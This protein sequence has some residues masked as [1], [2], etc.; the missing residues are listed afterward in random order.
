[1][2]GTVTARGF[3]PGAVVERLIGLEPTTADLGKVVLYQLSYS[4]VRGPDPTEAPG[5]VKGRSPG[6]GPAPVRRRSPDRRRA[7]EGHEPRR[8]CEAGLHL[9]PEHLTVGVPAGDSEVQVRVPEGAP[10]LLGEGVL[11]QPEPASRR[12]RRGTPGWRGR[13][14]TRCPGRPTRSP[15]RSAPSSTFT[16]CSVAFEMGTYLPS[17]S[18][19]R[20]FAGIA[21]SLADRSIW[22]FTRWSAIVR[23][24]ASSGESVPPRRSWRGRRAGRG[25]PSGRAAASGPPRTSGGRRPRPR[26]PRRPPLR[27]RSVRSR[28]GRHLTAG[29]SARPVVAS[30]PAFVPENS[31]G[32][33]PV[34]PITAASSSGPFQCSRA[35]LSALASATE[36]SASR[37]T[38]GPRPAPPEASDAPS[39]RSAG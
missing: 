11:H 18:T 39:A 31:G 7:G 22:N 17:I 3:S 29:G 28:V 16:P 25:R 36:A 23:Q 34:S 27:S 12:P 4:R 24:N 30:S 15:S 14:R 35:Q 26:A 5:R 13:P 33:G 19:V 21:F 32:D 37:F 6:P 20:W 1:M 10:E 9:R 2:A 8:A 38:A